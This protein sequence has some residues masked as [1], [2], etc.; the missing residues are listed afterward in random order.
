M[1]VKIGGDRND[2]IGFKHAASDQLVPYLSGTWKYG[3]QKRGWEEGCVFLPEFSVT[4]LVYVTYELMKP[5][6]V[7]SMDVLCFDFR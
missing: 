5:L 1:G 4:C 6:T 3:P 2:D 7:I